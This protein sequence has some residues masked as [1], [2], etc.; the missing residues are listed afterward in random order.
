MVKMMKGA[1]PE[2]LKA[3]KPT[4]AKTVQDTAADAVDKGLK[5]FF[6]IK[7]MTA[8]IA[9]KLKNGGLVTLFDLATTREDEVAGLLECSYGDA[10]KLVDGAKDIVLSKMKF[11]TAREANADKKRRQF[12]IKVGSNG[13][14]NLLGGGI[15]SMS[16]LG[17]A[18]RLASGKTQICNE[19]MV[20]V[21][22][23][24]WVCPECHAR[25][26]KGATC[27]VCSKEAVKAKAVM[28]ETEPDTFHLERLVQIAIGKGYKELAAEDAV[29]WDNL[30]VCGADQ[31]PTM[32]AQ[33]MQ[34]K[35]VQKALEE[36]EPIVLICVDSFNAKIRGSWGKTENLPLRTR[37]LGEHFNLIEVLTSKYNLTWILTCQVIAGPRQEQSMQSMVKFGSDSYF[38]GGDYLGHSVNNWLS[39]VQIKTDVYQAIL[40]DSS[41]LPRGSATFTITGKG[42]VDGVR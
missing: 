1:T 33:Y 35:I 5:Q 16:I 37:E 38:A 22:A 29:G 12:F 18:G 14:N 34:Y 6:M 4:E 2:E 36:D 3:E 42:L 25:L 40:F 41:Y 21:V 39:L 11:K 23:K 30:M 17:L 15:P 26:D 19:A 31:I 28:I 27:K 24:L 13:V 8:A 32:R 20:E 7:G 10:K 9:L